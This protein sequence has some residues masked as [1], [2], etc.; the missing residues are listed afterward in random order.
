MLVAAP[1]VAERSLR[2]INLPH[3]ANCPVRA[4]GQTSLALTG[5]DS[6]ELDKLLSKKRVEELSFNPAPEPLRSHSCLP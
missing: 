1:P 4:L 3:R 2:P 6:I 5:V